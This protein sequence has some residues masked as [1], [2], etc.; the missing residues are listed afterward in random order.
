MNVANSYLSRTVARAAKD[1]VSSHTKT[2]PVP[3]IALLIGMIGGIIA[4]ALTYADAARRN[5]PI[6][7]RY[8]WS[9]GV[10]GVGLGSPFVIYVY[11]D[12]IIQL[13]Y[14]LTESAVVVQSPR[15]LVALLS[16]IGL[17]IA[18]AATLA[19]GFG[20]RLGPLKSA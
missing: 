5:L 19:Y 12:T 9:G 18:A 2:K 8:L 15:E 17:A 3:L 11:E 10:A 7:T 1:L 20:S 13:G 4:T 16:F 14:N 6:Q